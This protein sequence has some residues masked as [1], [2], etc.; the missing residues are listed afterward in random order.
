M[1]H[2]NFC[3]AEQAHFLAYFRRT[4]A[5]AQ[6]PS[7]AWGESC[8][9]ESALP[10]AIDSRFALASL[11]PLFAQTTQKNYACPAGYITS[12]RNII[13]IKGA[14]G[15]IFVVAVVSFFC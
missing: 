13:S 2:I 12:C 4:E 8:M 14:A 15:A 6:S 9:G 11:S 7:H 5:K 10:L 3:P 1:T